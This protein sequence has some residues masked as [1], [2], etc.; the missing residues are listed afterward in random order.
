M[1]TEHE[2]RNLSFDIETSSYEVAQAV[3]DEVIA[4]LSGDSSGG[5]ELYPAKDPGSIH[6]KIGAVAVNNIKKEG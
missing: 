6:V 4:S 5:I 2:L 1:A 3:A